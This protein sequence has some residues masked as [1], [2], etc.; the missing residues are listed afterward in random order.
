MAGD[1]A[2]RP[3]AV[4]KTPE[5]LGV[6]LF[7]PAPEG[8]DP[9]KASAR[10]L[11]RY[12]YPARPD[13]ELHPRRY[14]RWKQMV[15]R[16]ISLIQPEFAVLPIP[17]GGPKNPGPEPHPD[18]STSANWGGV[19]AFPPN[20]DDPVTDVLGSW[21]VPH[22]IAP[23]PYSGAYVCSTWIGI[24]G[25]ESSALLQAGTQQILWP[26][27]DYS[28]WWQWVPANPN[29]PSASA[30]ITNVPVSPGD[31]MFC[32]IDAG[33]QTGATEATIH[34]TNGTTGVMT[35]FIV[36]APAGTEV[37]GGSAEWIV[38]MPLDTFNGLPVKLPEYTFVYFD[39]CLAF[40]RSGRGFH[41]NPGELVTMVSAL[42]A[43]M[44]TPN[45]LTDDLVRIDWHSGIPGL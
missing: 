22:V 6:R 33:S 39:N 17:P 20:F 21:T 27:P 42:N 10:E 45:I 25:W 40:A 43:P 30:G 29:A 41:A 35:S 34:L 38:E 4:R 9:I 19:V 11:R 14:E 8:F 7:E 13:A 2:A 5:E 31:V 26:S 24:D 18:S 12:G 3:G 37:L 16:S 1:A 32:E 28:A 36:H 44:S 23:E 15:S